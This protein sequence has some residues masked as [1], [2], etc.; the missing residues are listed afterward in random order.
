MH[1]STSARFQTNARRRTVI[2][3]NIH[4]AGKTEYTRAA[5]LSS[6]LLAEQET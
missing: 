6:N 2:P 5:I 4:K 1:S 3:I